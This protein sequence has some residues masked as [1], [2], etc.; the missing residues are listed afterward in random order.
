M[1]CTRQIADKVGLLHGKQSG[2]VRL[3]IKWAYSESVTRHV[4]MR[5]FPGK[6]TGIVD[7]V[8]SISL[9]VLCECRVWPLY[10]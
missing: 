8:D 2:C 10:L 1:R 9:T 7:V 3:Q 4:L 5:V 6:G